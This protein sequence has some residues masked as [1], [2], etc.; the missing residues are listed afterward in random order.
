M[1]KKLTLLF[2]VLLILAVA[3]TPAMAQT[4]FNVTVHITSVQTTSAGQEFDFTTDGTPSG[5]NGFIFYFP[6]SGTDEATAIANT[7]AALASVL[8]AEISGHSVGIQGSLATSSFGFCV[9]SAI[10]VNNQ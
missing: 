10:F 3:I 1:N 7:H 5:C 6:P 8:S 2:S 9:I 4:G